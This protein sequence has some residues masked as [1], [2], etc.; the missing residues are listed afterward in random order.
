MNEITKLHFDWATALHPADPFTKF[1]YKYFS[2]ETERADMQ[3]GRII[4]FTLG[5]LFFIGYVGSFIQLP[6]NFMKVIVL[7]Y[8]IGLG[9]FVIM[10]FIAIKL[11]TLRLK[12]IAKELGVSLKEYN[13]LA[14]KFY[15]SGK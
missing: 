9:L 6:Y 4:L 13:Q 12:K 7:M 8:C 5:A 3:P 14:E 2:S 11:N 15:P 1:V 10:L